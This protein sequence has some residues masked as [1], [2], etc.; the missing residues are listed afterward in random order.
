MATITS[1]NWSFR[2]PDDDVPDG[3]IIE[4][5]NFSQAA[6]DT[7][8]L[9]GKKL[10]I[11]GGNF[12]NVKPQ[13]GWTIEGGNWCQKEFCG[14][15]H[16]DFVE[17]GVIPVCKIDCKHRFGAEKLWEVCT[18]EEY[19]AERKTM[20]IDATIEK[21]DDADGVTQQT[22]KRRR[23]QYQDAVVKSGSAVKKAQKKAIAP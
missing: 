3:S 20:T 18:E 7:E 5:G 21:E 1:G 6:P 19:R 4:G 9:V 2:D 13:P 22:F 14:H 15:E 23:Y 10:T 16:P 8:I 12:V 11:R 17:R